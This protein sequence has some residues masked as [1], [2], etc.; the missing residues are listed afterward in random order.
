MMVII[1]PYYSIKACWPLVCITR[2]KVDSE[3]SGDVMSFEHPVI[4]AVVVINAMFDIHPRCT[5]MV[6]ISIEIIKEVYCIYPL[7]IFLAI[8]CGASLIAQCALIGKE[9]Q[10]D[11]ILIQNCCIIIFI[12]IYYKF[13]CLFSRMIPQD[14]D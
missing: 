3:C 12:P 8:W 4:S 9:M 2:R 14:H 7:P 13:R 5:I 11:H 1:L 6:A 10:N